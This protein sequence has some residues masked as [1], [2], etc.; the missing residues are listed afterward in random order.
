V[1]V[2]WADDPHIYADKVL[3]MTELATYLG[4]KYG[5]WK[6]LPQRF[7]KKWGT[8]QL[9]RAADGRLRRPLRLPHLLR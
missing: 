4:Q 7:G 3:D 5:G 2:A 8:N 1:V 6:A 9:D